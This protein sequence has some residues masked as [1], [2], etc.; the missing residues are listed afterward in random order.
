[1]KETKALA[2][3]INTFCSKLGRSPIILN[4]IAKEY[5][6]KNE[7]EE[8]NQS[9]SNLLITDELENN[10]LYKPKNLGLLMSNVFK[11]SKKSIKGAAITSINKIAKMKFNEKNISYILKKINELIFI[12][13][14][15][16]RENISLGINQIMKEMFLYLMEIKIES[17]LDEYFEELI[18]FEN[19]KIEEIINDFKNNY[20]NLKAQELGIENLFSQTEI[21]Q[22]NDNEGSKFI[23]NKEQNIANSLNYI[24]NN[25]NEKVDEEGKRILYKLM[26]TF[27]ANNFYIEL[28]QYCLEMIDSQIILDYLKENIQLNIERSIQE[29]IINSKY[30]E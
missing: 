30:K 1:M 15:S 6:E 27:F 28:F 8:N 26:M 7:P 22:N 2:N 21:V 9:S 16:F 10:I 13:G 17:N 12:D 25:L 18:N 3:N 14:L 23:L 5:S 11:E 19:M 4:V 24:K 20:F 29:I